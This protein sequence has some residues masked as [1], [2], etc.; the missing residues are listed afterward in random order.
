MKAVLCKVWRW[1]R[2]RLLR[3]YEWQSWPSYWRFKRGRDL[4]E[5]QFKKRQFKARALLRDSAKV[6]SIF[7]QVIRV[8]FWRLIFSIALVFIFSVLDHHLRDWNPGWLNLKLEKEAQ[9]EFLATLGGASAAFLTLYFTAISVV[10]STAYARVPGN[11][12]SLI[13]KEEIG[14]VYF[15][16]LA[17]FA[18]VVTVILTAL[19]FGYQIGPLNTLLASFLCLFSIFGFVF[20]GVRAFEYFDPTVLVTLLNQ[21]IFRE[22]KSVTPDGYQ[23]TDSSFQTH[24][25]RLAEELLNNYADLVTVSSQK[26]NLHSKGLV[27]LGKGLLLV[28]NVYAKEKV[29]IPSSSYWFRR[30]YRHKNW[31]LTSYT[32][33]EM[34]LVTGTIIQ[35]DTVPDL[36]WFE[37]DAARILEEIFSQLGERRDSAGTIALTTSLQNHMGGMSQCLAVSESLHIFKAVVPKLRAQTGSE[38]FTTTGD[39]SQGINRLAISELYGCGLINVLL[40]LSDE[41]GKL[42]SASL[43]EIIRAVNWLEQKTFYTGKILPRTVTQEIESLQE[44]L[45]FEIRVE[46]KIIS[47][48]WL[49]KEMLA[50]AC[51][52]FLDDVTKSL[53]GEFEITFGN[54]AERQLDGKN[55]VLAAQLIQRGLEACDKLAK[56]FVKFKAL[57]EEYVALNRSKEYIWPEISWDVF[58]KGIATL[59][60]R[61]ITVLAKSSIELA[62]LPESQSWPDFFGHAYSVLAEECFRAM[63]AQ[64]EELFQ[65][66]FAAFFGL[67]LQ[68]S[69]KLRRKFIGDLQ[70]IRLS[71]EPLADLMTLSGYAALFSE[72]DGKNYWALVQQCWNNY[73]ALYADSNSK[74]QFI[75]LLCFTVEPNMRI[76]SRS[77]LRT[78]W[79]QMFRGVLGARGVFPERAFWD[80]RLQQANHPSLLIRV[81]GRS[82]YLFTKA[83]DV[84][85]ALYI[86]KL[87]EAAGIE[88]PHDVDY[89][90]RALQPDTDDKNDPASENE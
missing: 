7:G 53:V 79:Q 44:C 63:A 35:P 89:L 32:E 76:A 90:E 4:L 23:W 82:Q 26:E 22:I 29:R 2:F 64:K 3:S 25:Q 36:M 83:D 61:L 42:N 68:G 81:F 16:V 39:S 43:E 65:T 12:R 31:L 40:G 69:D 45:D 49:Q 60:E 75:Q 67:A 80:D 74:Q 73:L 8:I 28:T 52:R 41:L 54:E 6:T 19:A 85:L 57:H 11:I 72:L 20:L 87:P 88:K 15:G 30:T 18:G 56:H 86:F 9:R 38:K 62:N 46:G 5:F 66:V 71:C 14:S 48:E 24:H 77:V 33:I 13:I 10:V 1:W 70:N 78:R 27:E 37:T 51:V 21:R 47:P 34:A 50:L 17:Q 58:Q 55:H 84:F 59:R